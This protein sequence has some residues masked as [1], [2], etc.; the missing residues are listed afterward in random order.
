[1]TTGRINQVHASPQGCRSRSTRIHACCNLPQSLVAIHQM[2]KPTFCN[3]TL[4]HIVTHFQDLHHDPHSQD[5]QTSERYHGK[6]LQTQVLHAEHAQ[7]NDSHNHPFSSPNQR[8][9][10]SSPTVCDSL[11]PNPR[12]KNT[13]RGGAAG[14]SSCT[15]WCKPAGCT[16]TRKDSI[17][18]C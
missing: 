3:V 15:P 18:N 6:S 1:M 11:Q 12:T 13:F 4:S 8:N 2:F 16:Y 5:T 7:P 10:F 14:D 9:T 17:Q